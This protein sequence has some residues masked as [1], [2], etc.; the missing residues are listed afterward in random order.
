MTPQLTLPHPDLHRRPE[1]LILAAQV[2]GS[3]LHPVLNKRLR[4]IATE[5]KPESWG[6]FFAQG[7]SLLDF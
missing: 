2:W 5:V 7:K 3:Y 4:E 6:S 1:D